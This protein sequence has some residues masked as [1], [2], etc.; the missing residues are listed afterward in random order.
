MF[1]GNKTHLGFYNF[2]EY[3]SFSAKNGFCPTCG[4]TL[5]TANPISNFDELNLVLG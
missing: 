5:A 4:A 1:E 3:D 2:E